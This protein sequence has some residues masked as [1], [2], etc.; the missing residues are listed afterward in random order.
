[1]SLQFKMKKKNLSFKVT[2]L[3]GHIA[4]DIRKKLV[5]SPMC[6]QYI[7]YSFGRSPP[8]YNQ[9]YLKKQVSIS[10]GCVPTAP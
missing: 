9:K 8:V 6:V 4:F 5:T 7:C 2:P 1:M 10:V 3:G